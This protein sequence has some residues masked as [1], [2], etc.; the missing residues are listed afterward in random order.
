MSVNV[1]EVS[2]QAKWDLSKPA[3]KPE[4]TRVNLH[5]TT[6]GYSK[7]LKRRG[8]WTE[9][10]VYLHEPGSYEGNISDYGGQ[11]GRSVSGITWIIEVVERP[12]IGSSDYPAI[13]PPAGGLLE[14]RINGVPYTRGMSVNV[15][16][17]SFQAKWDLS[18]PAGKPEGTRVNL[19]VTTTGYSK[20]LKRRGVWTEWTVY[21]HEPGSYEGNISDYGGQWGRSVSGITWTLNILND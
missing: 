15:G 7:E 5:V 2:F 9:W 19:H 3:G 18:K 11:W 8:V 12:V 1:G 14:L 21:L 16:E 17:V 13:E 4:G 10:T 20:E 6:T